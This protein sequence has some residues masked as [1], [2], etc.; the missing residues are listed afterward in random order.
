M[1][2]AS[3]ARPVGMFD[4]FFNKAVSWVTGGDFCHSEFIFVYEAKEFE[5][6]LSSENGHEH[7]K[8]TFSNYI[9]DGN[10][11]ICFY[12]LW[13]TTVSYR[14]LKHDHNN[15][16]YKM[17]DDNQFK[18]VEINIDK[19]KKD[20]VIQFLFGEIGKTYD[21]PGALM[22]FIPRRRFETIYP[23]YFCSQ[24]MVSALHQIQ[25]YRDINPGSVTPNYLYSVL[26]KS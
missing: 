10:V 9:E 5:A 20:K 19:T 6:L 13:G 17:P 18:T 3:F 11:N 2:Y 21:Y 15:P 14:L 4:N 12:I 1:L 24:L 23:R 7:L 25:M 22:Y 8:K 16:F 26:T